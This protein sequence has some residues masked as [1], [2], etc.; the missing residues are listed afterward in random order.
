MKPEHFNSVRSQG[1]RRTPRLHGARSERGDMLLESLI[2]I[3]LMLAVGLGLTYS[4]AR[5]VQAQRDTSL[6]GLALQA[7][8]N[9]LENAPDLQTFCAAPTATSVAG[10]PLQLSCSI[11]PDANVQVSVGDGSQTALTATLSAMP[12]AMALSASA[13]QSLGSGSLF[14]L[15]P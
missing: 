9:A 6:H 5:M 14:T 3:L 10:M 7:V 13:P 1:R 15:S 2:G 8:R 4:A 11:V 12:S